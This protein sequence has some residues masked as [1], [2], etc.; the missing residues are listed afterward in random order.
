MASKSEIVEALEITTIS[1]DKSIDALVRT[2]KAEQLP[3]FDYFKFKLSLKA[4]KELEIDEHTAIKS[5]FATASTLGV[6]KD[7]IIKTAKHYQSLL[8]KE[9]ED[10][11][12]AAES[13]IASRIASKEDEI[14]K[15]ED[16]LQSCKEQILSLQKLISQLDT[17]LTKLNSE[18]DS[19]TTKIKDA[20]ES[21]EKG[22]KTIYDKIEHDIHQLSQIE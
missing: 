16:Q 20:K 14:R 11:N 2:L 4:L 5:A 22:F 17:K 8:E 7:K 10:F 9:K 21:F 19:A 13:Q 6:T 3:G 18:K 12:K 1:N 15:V